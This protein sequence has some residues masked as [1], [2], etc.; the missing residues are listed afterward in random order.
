MMAVCFLYNAINVLAWCALAHHFGHWWIAL[1][2]V[3]TQ[4]HYHSE[5]KN[6]REDGS[7]EA[8]DK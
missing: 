1:F 6:E 5:R 8:I 7:H 2:A 4:L 3:V